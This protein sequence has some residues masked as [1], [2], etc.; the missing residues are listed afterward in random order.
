MCL[1]CLICMYDGAFL[2][3]FQNCNQIRFFAKICVSISNFTSGPF[4]ITFFVPPVPNSLAHWVNVRYLREFSYLYGKIRVVCSKLLYYKE[5]TTLTTNTKRLNIIWHRICAGYVRPF[6][7]KLT[8]CS[9][10]PYCTKSFPE[11]LALKHLKLILFYLF[12]SMWP[13]YIKDRIKSTYLFFGASLA[14]SAAAATTVFRTP[15][16][17]RIVSY[18]G[19][20]VS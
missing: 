1:F 10:K 14:I 18:Q 7:Q 12:S 2:R 5:R 11:S 8:L 6:N 15:A 4:F 16:L 17:L 19:W 20:M 3:S 9:C 13:Q